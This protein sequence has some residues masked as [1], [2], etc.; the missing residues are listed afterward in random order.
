MA[1]KAKSQV[2][3]PVL[4]LLV[5]DVV[6]QVEEVVSEVIAEAPVEVERS[7]LPFHETEVYIDLAE[8]PSIT[9]E[10]PVHKD[11]FLKI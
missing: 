6:E 7:H 4:D 5:E 8:T 10:D 1:R 9:P 11:W 3:E 2:A